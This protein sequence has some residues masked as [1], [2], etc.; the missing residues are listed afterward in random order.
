MTKKARFLII[1]IAILI[2]TAMAPL[3]GQ[4]VLWGSPAN[5]TSLT[6]AGSGNQLDASFTFQVGTF[7]EAGVPGWMPSAANTAEWADHWLAADSAVY[8]ETFR[9]FTGSS[10]FDPALAG[11]QGYIWGFDSNLAEGEWILLTDPNWIFPSFET[12]LKFPLSWQTSRAST[13]VVGSSNNLP[14]AAYHLKTAKI[15]I[16][17]PPLVPAHQW[18]GMFFTTPELIDSLIGA[19]NSDADEDGMSNLVEFALG[20]LPREARSER[21][22]VLGFVES[23]G[24]EYLTLT[25][26]RPPNA[27]V[28]YGAEVSPDLKTWDGGST[29]VTLLRESPTEVVFRDNTPISEPGNRF[30]RLKVGV[31]E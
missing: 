5:R 20:R 17:P 18:L 2:A 1:L 25:I 31:E 30:M 15:T 23:G 27:N 9:A 28:V 8:H 4:Q 13:V 24:L 21:E 22:P 19:W 7:F 6:S 10:P 14:D 11:G 3:H 29:H 26:E 12:G 16:S